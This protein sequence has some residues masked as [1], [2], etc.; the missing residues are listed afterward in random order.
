MQP[1]NGVGP[2]LY[3]VPPGIVPTFPRFA[4][5]SLF[6]LGCSE[7]KHAQDSGINHYEFILYGRQ[8]AMNLAV[9]DNICASY[10]CNIGYSCFISRL[11]ISI[12]LAK[13]LHGIRGARAAR[14]KYF[15]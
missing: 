10:M 5:Y 7:E 8:C 12:I 1:G 14:V 4:G 9:Q 13:I 6:T 11:S 2:P 15:K 3:P